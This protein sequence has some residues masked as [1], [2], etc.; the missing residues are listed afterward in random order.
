[1]F[2]KSDILGKGATGT[3]YKGYDYQENQKVAIKVI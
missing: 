2:L 3:V 1:M